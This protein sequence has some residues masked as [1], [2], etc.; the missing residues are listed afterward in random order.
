MFADEA[1]RETAAAFPFLRQQRVKSDGTSQLCLADYLAPAGDWLG[2]FALTAGLGVED[3]ERALRASGDDYGAI[4]AAILADRLAEAFAEMMHERV[5][6]RIWGYAAGESFVPASLP[7]A[8]YRGIRPAPGYPACP[9]HRDKQA[10][11]GLLG[12]RERLG[13]DLTETLMMRP[14]ASVS[15]LLFQPP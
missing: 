8:G 1:R 7:T 15:R 5:R 10:I 14:T 2:V 3:F 12:A 9:D 6:T 13:M 11:F 4:M